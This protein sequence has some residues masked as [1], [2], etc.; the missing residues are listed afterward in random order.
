MR[1]ESLTTRLFLCSVIFFLYI[2]LT[3]YVILDLTMVVDVVLA[4][5]EGFT[6]QLFIYRHFNYMLIAFS[7]SYQ[8]KE[9]LKHNLKLKKL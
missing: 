3:L 7:L 1:A 8:N 9:V 4:K 2:I 6:Y 5:A